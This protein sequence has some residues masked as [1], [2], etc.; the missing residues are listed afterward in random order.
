MR[1]VALAVTIGLIGC[2]GRASQ[3]RPSNDGGQP[4]VDAI[5]DVVDGGAGDPIGDSK[6]R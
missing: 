3:N 4:P 1:G 2:G 5:A 6:R